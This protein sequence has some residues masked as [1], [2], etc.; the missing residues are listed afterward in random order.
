MKAK[1]FLSFVVSLSLAASLAV[2]ALAQEGTEDG[3]L[4]RYAFI[5]QYIANA[6]AA[7]DFDAEAWYQEYVAWDVDD[8]TKE[9]YMEW[10]E[11]D[12]EEFRAEMWQSYAWEMG[13]PIYEEAEAAYDAYVVEYYEAAHPGELESL[14][15][16]DL[17]AR[18]GYTETLTP[19][20]QFIKDWGLEGEDEARSA[21]L[22]AYASERLSEEKFHAD[23]LAYQEEYPEKW[24]EFDADAYFGERYAYGFDSK[25]EYMETMELSEEVF[26]ESMFVE[27]VEN[28]RWEWE[29]EGDDNWYWDG[30]DHE[31][32][33]TLYA[34]GQP[35]DTDVTAADGVTYAD[36]AVLGE[37]LGAQFPGSDPISIRSA[38]E[39]AGWDVT[40]NS[41]RRQ[42]VLLDR[43]RLLTGVIVPGYGWVEEDIS[44]LD[45]LAEKARTVSAQEPGQSYQT[46]GTVDVSYTALNSLD[47]DE[48]YTAKLKVETLTRDKTCEIALSM[49]LT[50]LLGLLPK[51]ALEEAKAQLPK[52]A[53]DLKTLLK[54]LKVDLIWDGETG[55]LYMNAP[56][57]ALMDPTPGVT[58]DTWYA[59]DLSEALEAEREELSL[60]EGLYRSLLEDSGSGWAGAGD[61]YSDFVMEKGLFHIL[62][63]PH[64]V[65]EKNGTLTWKLD[66]EMISAALDAFMGA[67]GKPGGWGDASLFKECRLEMTMD[68]KGNTS[69]D[70]AL[71]P[72]AEG[73]TTAIY[74]NG[75]PYY[76]LMG[77][78]F[79]WRLLGMTDFRYAASGKTS[80][81]GG[82]ASLE[83]HWKN[84]F[85][86]A[87]D[88]ETTRKEVRTAPRTTPPDGAEI[89]EL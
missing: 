1:R 76:S 10:L 68:P 23:F 11:L 77:G 14:S 83:L 9:E 63:G 71:R 86:L 4:D 24:A 26:V 5:D 59:F 67:T 55:T 54:G 89:M 7:E 45:R 51:E 25:E 36:P 40:W 28:N 43:E 3:F 74:E 15:T 29:H 84:S 39:A 6:P 31:R 85:K 56:I 87:L 12:E 62:F 22:S 21:L 49:D 58:A 75:D 81:R 64:A 88:M 52:T 48:T 16:E 70:M 35:V 57:V 17:L 78:L 60:A 66:G 53:R 37:I 19:M 34:N 2:P 13:L 20:E 27:Y 73:I 44:G 32:D 79:A 38:A 8:M 46:T 80:A 47:G 65:T 18:L 82:T 61:A 72:D 33:I 41:Y 69:F 50:D 42:V 30:Q